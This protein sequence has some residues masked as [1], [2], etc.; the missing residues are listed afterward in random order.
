MNNPKNLIYRLIEIV[1]TLEPHKRTKNPYQDHIQK[2]I[3]NLDLEDQIVLHN[4]IHAITILN[5]TTR[6]L[7]G[8]TL[9]STREDNINALELILPNRNKI[10]Q[11][12][13]L[14][15]QQIEEFFGFK[16]FIKIE[17]QDQLRI[18][19]TT[20]VNHANK[21]IAHNLMQFVGLTPGVSQRSIYQ[22]IKPE[23]MEEQIEEPSAFEQASEE[24]TEGKFFE[25]LQYRTGFSKND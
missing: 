9:V 12:T 20:F 16:S 1:K 3:I 17:A 4:L 22:L 13:L 14:F 18:S 23:I 6:K 24:F 2:Q 10:S 7:E 11:S 5:Q 21:L 19:K 25:E 15:K 8:K